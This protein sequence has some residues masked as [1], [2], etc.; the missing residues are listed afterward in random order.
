[1][2]PMNDSSRQTVRPPAAPTQAREPAA[3]SPLTP[4]FTVGTTTALPSSSVPAAAEGPGTS[5]TRLKSEGFGMEKGMRRSSPKS[6]FRDVDGGEMDGDELGLFKG[7]SGQQ[8]EKR[9]FGGFEFGGMRK[10][11]TASDTSVPPSQAPPVDPGTKM[12]GPPTTS[13]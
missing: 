7:G 5:S 4:H 9:D 1:M 11:T 10:V 12:D 8:K 13:S 6:L 2:Q 3:Q